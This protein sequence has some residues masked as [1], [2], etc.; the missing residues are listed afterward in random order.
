MTTT[1]RS[2]I[3]AELGWTWR[4]TLGTLL[5]TD[6]N[7]LVARE[8]LADGDGPAQA[9]AVWHAL[10]QALANGRSAVYS[11]GALPQSMFGGTITVRL[12][13]VKALLLVNRS[14]GPGYLVVGGAES[15]QWIGPF[16]MFGDT[17]RLDAGSP[18]L[19][20]S[21]RDG[22]AVE[23]GFERLKLEAVGGDARYD[24]VLLGTAADGEGEQEDSSSHSSSEEG[25]SSSSSSG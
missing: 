9:D 22:W 7:R 1:L 21:V 20:A 14:E 16:G 6:N 17:L 8:D 4:D 13:K 15:G 25:S 24:L 11:L 2:A 5:F 18:L 10:D 19:M 12:A 3:H 23:P